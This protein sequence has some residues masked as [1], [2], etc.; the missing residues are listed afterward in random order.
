MATYSSS[1]SSVQRWSFS[2]ATAATPRPMKYSWL[3]VSLAEP[4]QPASAATTR[5]GISFFMSALLL[6]GGELA[7]LA[8][9]AEILELR[10]QGGPVRLVGGP[11]HQG[12]E[13]RVGLLA[14]SPARRLELL[15]GLGVE[16]LL[17]FESLGRQ[18]LP[19]LFVRRAAAELLGRDQGRRHDPGVQAVLLGRHLRVLPL[20]RGHRDVLA[21]I[22]GPH[23][24]PGPV[25]SLEEP[26]R[27]HRDL[28]LPEQILLVLQRR[29]VGHDGG[30]DRQECGGESHPQFSGGMKDSRKDGTPLSTI[31][32]DP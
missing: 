26:G 19:F 17:A 18:L 13:I 21:V 9:L 7:Q 25:R 1:F 4:P 16:A 6:D 32:R 23:L 29:G 31:L 3:S 11:G 28:L 14:G 15:L 27:L 2:M 5:A 10:H 30:E 24:L 8:F 22:R 12:V 20:H